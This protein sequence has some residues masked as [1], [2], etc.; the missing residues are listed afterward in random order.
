M[1][2][3]TGCKGIRLLIQ[4]LKQVSESVLAEMLDVNTLIVEKYVMTLY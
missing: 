4:K 1:I 2:I 3:I